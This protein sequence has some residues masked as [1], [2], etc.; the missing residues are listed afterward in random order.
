MRWLTGPMFLAVAVTLANAAEPVV[1]DDAA[2]LAFARQVAAR[3]LDPYGFELYWYTTAEPAMGVLCP[4]VV[5]YWL[6]LGMAVFGDRPPLL[7]LWMFPFVWL[8][9]WALREL[10]RRFA[11]GTER[12]ALPLLVLSPAVLPTVNLMLDIPAVGLGLAAL[13]LFVRACDRGSWRLAATAGLVA[14]LAMQA[15]YTAL[16]VPAVLGWYGLTHRRADFAV[17]AGG[18]AAA[19]FAGWELLVAAEYGVSHFLFHLAGQR[20]AG[21]PVAWL[22]LKWGLLPG[23]LGGLGLLAVGVGLYAGRAV[24]FPRSVLAG[25]AVA[26]VTGVGLVCGGADVRPS[27]VWRAAGAAVL[28]TAAGGATIL[29]VRRWK[30]LAVRRSPDSW[31][32]V[33]WVA[34]ELAGYFALT[35]FPAARRVIGPTVALGVL[36][37]RVVSRSGRRP[38]GWVVPFGITVGVLTAAL[39]TWDAYPEKVLA[40]RAAEVVRDRPPALQVWYA[41]HWGFQY[42]S[43]RAGM[44]PAFRGQLLAAGDYLV[45]PLHPDPDGFYRP[46]SVNGW[47]LPPADAERLAE[48]VWDDWLCATTIPSFYGGPNPVVG[49]DHPRLRVGVFRVVRGWVVP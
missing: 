14:G 12:A 16:L 38:P 7:K 47:L 20:S 30:P 45:L 23:L 2:Y 8:L 27:V 26:W 1:V 41:G 9:A 18:V 35:P 3:P 37:A 5:P 34:V 17:L 24:G 42:Y 10:L 6:G 22:G 32:V 28:L 11:R 4:P 31:F 25:A 19:L 49:R 46:D 33:G 29:L 48:L 39:D 43:E 36:A 13:V 44:R 15:K 21:G 40:E